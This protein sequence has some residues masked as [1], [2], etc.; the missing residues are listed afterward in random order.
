M[1]GRFPPIGTE[2]FITAELTRRLRCIRSRVVSSAQPQVQLPLPTLCFLD[3]LLPSLQTGL[4]TELFGPSVSSGYL[5]R[6][7][8]EQH[9]NRTLQHDAGIN[10]G[11]HGQCGE[12]CCADRREWKSVCRNAN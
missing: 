2:A 12:V 10:P 5:A 3:R 11:C 4:Q 6:I 1:P 9:S 7:Q 8:C